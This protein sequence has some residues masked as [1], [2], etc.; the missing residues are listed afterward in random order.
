MICHDSIIFLQPPL[1]YPMSQ[2]LVF[3]SLILGRAGGWAGEDR[4]L[5]APP[6]GLH[7]NKFQGWNPSA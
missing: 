5:M 3:F 7:E 2:N 6:A 4:L 1:L